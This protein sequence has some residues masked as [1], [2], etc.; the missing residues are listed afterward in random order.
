VGEGGLSS[1]IKTTIKNP[2]DEVKAPAV[3]ILAILASNDSYRFVFALGEK[4]IW[5]DLT[6]LSQEP[7][8]GYQSAGQDRRLPA[9][10]Q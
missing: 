6:C 5:C 2:Y 8:P 10:T 3:T 9:E 4:C 7:N 1:I